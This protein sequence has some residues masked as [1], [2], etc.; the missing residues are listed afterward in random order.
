MPHPILN[1]I[2]YHA[3]YDAS[4]SEA[5]QYAYM[6][7]FSGIQLAVE[8]PHLSFDNL[9]AAEIK[10]IRASIQ[11]SR[12]Y[13]NLH[14]PDE[15]ASLFLYNKLL[16][17]GVLSY[18][19]SLFDFA[20]KIK[21]PL[22][23]IHAGAPITFATDTSPEISVPEQDWQLYGDALK[24]NLDELVTLVDQRF[25]L[26]V[27]NHHFDDLT[28]T[29]LKPYL[30]ERRIAL[31]WDIPKSWHKPGVEQ[32]FWDNL[33]SIKQ[34]HIHDI[35]RDRTGLLRRHRVIGTGEVDFAPY[36]ARL[37]SAEVMDY[38]IEVRPREKAKESLEAIRRLVSN[39]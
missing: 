5:L 10:N 37:R 12:T 3:V 1:R 29:V 15:A 34:V 20:A 28:M 30:A 39:L 23:T 2:S 33:D 8:S 18:Y 22:V 9:S 32:F 11:S 16:W 19:R 6:N 13:I 38:C 17:R 27:E 36:L 4:A 25:I 14:G 21:S 31:C 35:G 24:R 7:G 26:C